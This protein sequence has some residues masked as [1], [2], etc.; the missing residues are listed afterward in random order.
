MKLS[1]HQARSLDAMAV[2]LRA[3]D[4][5]LA[6]L[7]SAP[8]A[9]RNPLAPEKLSENAAQR[10]RDD[11]RMILPILASFI[12]SIVPLVVGTVTE[13]HWLMTLGVLVALLVPAATIALMSYRYS[14]NNPRDKT[15]YF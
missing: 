4:P 9:L 10:F 11:L 12:L 15:T 7:L 8:A 3:S 2:R 1:R 14:R 5:E 6:D 13:V